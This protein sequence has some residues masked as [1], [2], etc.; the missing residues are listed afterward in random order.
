VSR[1]RA[2][3]K[4]KGLRR[5]GEVDTYFMRTVVRSSGIY[6]VLSTKRYLAYCP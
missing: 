1:N 6:I 3:S 5:M 2:E 4:R